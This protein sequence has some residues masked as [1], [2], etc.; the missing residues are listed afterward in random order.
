MFDDRM[1]LRTISQTN[2]SVAIET[3]NGDRLDEPN[4]RSARGHRII[5]PIT[6]HPANTATQP[7][8]K[9]NPDP[10][11]DP[12]A[13]VRSNS[14][15]ASAPTDSRTPHQQSATHS[16]AMP[17]AER[18]AANSRSRSYRADRFHQSISAPHRPLPHPHASRKR[19]HLRGIPSLPTMVR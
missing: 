9:A 3:R 10:L 11:P 18:F 2:I 1:T 5:C 19:T 17:T 16:Q 15:V 7:R 14:P 13:R 6:A 8:A 12:T 4:T